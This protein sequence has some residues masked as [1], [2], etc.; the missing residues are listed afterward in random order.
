M[1]E[2]WR[3]IE[4]VLPAG[5][6]EKQLSITRSNLLEF[7]NKSRSRGIYQEPG[8]L[9]R[10]AGKILPMLNH[11]DGLGKIIAFTSESPVIGDSSPEDTV[12]TISSMSPA[13][14]LD[15]VANEA[16]YA[17]F[18]L[19]DPA[20][21]P[22]YTDI[23]LQQYTFRSRNGAIEWMKLFE[24]GTL[25]IVKTIGLNDITLLEVHNE[26]LGVFADY[27]GLLIR[28]DHFMGYVY[29][30][31]I[32]MG[33]NDDLM[34]VFLGVLGTTLLDLWWRS[35]LLGAVYERSMIDA[36][37]AREGI[38]SFDMDLLDAPTIGAFV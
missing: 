14:D 15:V 27:A 16:N 6:I 31:S 33:F 28:R 24:N 23:D 34:T 20:W 12:E 26:G 32:E 2:Y 21:L 38:I 17:Q 37:L 3:S 5:S 1:P 22:I 10:T 11:R 25:E 9:K 29:S 19:D 18:E 7:E 30:T 36:G 13:D 4:E 35:S 8:R